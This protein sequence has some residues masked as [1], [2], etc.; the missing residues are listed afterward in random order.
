MVDHGEAFGSVLNRGAKALEQGRPIDSYDDVC[1][2]DGTWK[3]STSR[4][5][6]LSNLPDQSITHDGIL[7]TSAS[8][9]DQWTQMAKS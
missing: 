5:F 6:G 3:Q 1:T 2:K 9:L 8:T 4:C 7:L